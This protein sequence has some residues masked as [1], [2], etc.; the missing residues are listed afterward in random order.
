M[1]M[2]P[3]LLRPRAT[4]F[5]PK[6]LSGLALWLDPTDATS[7]TIDTGVSEWRDKS[8]NAK[9]F[10]Q[11][12]GNNQP[13]LSAI[14][15]K[16]ALSFNGTSHCLTSA[17]TLLTS[18]GLITFLQVVQGTFAGTAGH[19]FNHN[20]AA[21]GADTNQVCVEWRADQGSAW[22]FGT[23]R[24][25]AKSLR[26]STAYNADQRFDSVDVSGIGAITVEAAFNASSS[27]NVSRW[28]G[29]AALTTNGTSDVGA[30]T[31]MAIGARNNATKSLFF[32]GL[33]GE[34]LA[35]NRA[36][37]A[38]ELATVQAYLAKKWGYTTA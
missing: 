30:E 31:G 4:G 22:I 15:G 12:T 28:K 17:S 35:Y 24:T 7:Y 34:I 1:P 19:L 16:T 3:R 32:T 14:G 6:S 13:T 38:T 37:T 23:L 18:N 8:G 26:S 21:G 10:S 33:V 9:H 2:S 25:R 11:S 20:T 36:L 5:N 27:T 29:T